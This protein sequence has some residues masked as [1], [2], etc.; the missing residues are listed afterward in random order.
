MDFLEFLYI[1]PWYLQSVTT[2]FFFPISLLF[3]CLVW[4][5][6]RTSNTVWNKSDETGPLYL[7]PE[8]RKLTP[9][10]SVQCQLLFYYV[11]PLLF[12]QGFLLSWS[13]VVLSSVFPDSIEMVIWL[14]F[15]ILF[16]FYITFIDLPVLNHH[17][18][19]DLKWLYLIIS[20]LYSYFTRD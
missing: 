11:W 18:W 9:S 8:L 4:L 19:L 2:W 10:Y 13:T 12:F 14:L 20:T 5:L 15:L 1:K 7:V 3:L 6:S 16:M 17:W